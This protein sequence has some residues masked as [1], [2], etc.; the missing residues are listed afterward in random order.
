MW[1]QNL[2]QPL[3]QLSQTGEPASASLSFLRFATRAAD[4]RENGQRRLFIR[5]QNRIE[6]TDSLFVQLLASSPG[7]CRG[8]RKVGVCRVG[9]DECILEAPDGIPSCRR[10]SP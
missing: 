2:A 6:G 7:P 1:A 10:I 3:V 4:F 9:S 8:P 5:D